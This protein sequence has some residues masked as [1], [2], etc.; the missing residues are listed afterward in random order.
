MT[1][2][3]LGRWVVHWIAADGKRRSA[4]IETSE[5]DP[6]ITACKL[7]RAGSVAHH[8]SGPRGRSIDLEEIEAFCTGKTTAGDHQS[9]V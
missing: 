2:E 9:G 3:T 8:I 5:R 1:I 6:L 4:A 7:G